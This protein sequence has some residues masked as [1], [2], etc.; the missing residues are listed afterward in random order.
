MEALKLDPDCAA[1]RA[2]H[3]K[4]I[5]ALRELANLRDDHNLPSMGV[6]NMRREVTALMARTAE[7]DNG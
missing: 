2:A 6:D 5:E 3:V 1:L 4:A 7:N